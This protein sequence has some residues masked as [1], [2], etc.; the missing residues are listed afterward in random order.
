[1]C[2]IIGR[3][4]SGL[5]PL[6]C[7]S[8][9][10]VWLCRDHTSALSLLVPLMTWHVERNS[11]TPCNGHR[12]RKTVNTSIRGKTLLKYHRGKSITHTLC[13]QK[14]EHTLSEIFTFSLYYTQSHTHFFH[15][16]LHMQYVVM[17]VEG[18]GENVNVG[19]G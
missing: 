9:C 17:S 15:L 13:P 4:E 18:G 7:V 10:T 6:L 5:S 2:R 14:C 8:V 12:H 1:M 3:E 11:S 16:F 19:H